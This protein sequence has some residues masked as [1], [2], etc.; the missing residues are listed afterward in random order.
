LAIVKELEA[1]DKVIAALEVNVPLVIAVVP[2][3][4]VVPTP[5]R[6]IAPTPELRV[7]V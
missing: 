6:E 3:F 2:K 4:V 7:R 5:A 1:P